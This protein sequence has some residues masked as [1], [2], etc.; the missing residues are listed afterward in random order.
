MGGAGEA[1]A[2]GELV[3]RYRLAA[4]LTQEEVAERAGLSARTVA[5][6]E[7]GRTARPYRRSVRALADALAL[8]EPERHEL[9][10]AG[11]PVPAATAIADLTLAGRA[12]SAGQQQLPHPGSGPSRDRSHESP[13]AAPKADPNLGLPSALKYSLPPDTAAFTGRDDEVDRVTSAASATRCAVTGAVAILAIGGMPGIGKTTLAVHAAHRLAASFPDRQLFLDLHGHTPGRNPVTSEEALAG[14]LT[15]DGVDPRYLPADLEGRAA[16][17]RDRMSGQRVLLVLDNAASSA[18]VMPLLPGSAGCLVL[19]TSRRHLA[20]LPGVVTSITLEVLPPEQA[21][22][23]FLLLAPRARA[24]PPAVAE[25]V[26]LAGC[27]PLAISLLARMFAR[28]P[29]WTLAD[30]VAETRARL[31]TLTAEH[32]SIAA[33]FELSRQ[34][35]EPGQQEFF[36]YLGLHPGNSVDAYSAAALAGVE[37]ED[38]GRLLET[39]HGEGLLTEVGYRRYGMHDLIRRY[40]AERAAATPTEAAWEAA[41][42]RLMAYYQQAASIAQARLAQ[43]PGLGLG[44]PAPIAQPEFADDLE[45]LAWAR[46]ERDSMLVCLDRAQQRG[47]R[48]GI[49]ALTAGMTE[50]LRRDGPWSEAVARHAAAVLA[51]SDAGDSAALAA[52]LISLADA[53]NLAGDYQAAAAS[54]ERARE[55]FADVGDRRG[56]AD[57]LSVLAD[58][59]R[60][61]GDLGAA[62]CLLERSLAVFGELGDRFGEVKA[63]RVLGEV[64]ATAGDHV[65]AARLLGQ[66]LAVSRA[67]GSRLNEARILSDLAQIGR[68]A[69]DHLAAADAAT[70]ALALYT[71]LGD[72]HGQAQGLRVRAEVA[73]ATGACRAAESDALQAIQI[74]RELGDQVGQA[75][76][77]QTLGRA[78][79]SA[80]NCAAAAAALEQSLAIFRDR[81]HRSGQANALLWL[82]RTCR[83]L[84]EYSAAARHLGEALRLFIDTGDRGGE[85]TTLNETG[86]LLLAREDVLAAEA[87]YR[88]GLDLARQTSSS[89]DEAHAMAGLGRCAAA[90]GDTPSATARLRQAHAIFEREG[91]AEAASIAAEIESLDPAGT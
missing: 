18:Q 76:A 86:A 28:H 54:A 42:A 36:S 56:Q 25:L 77:L 11:R 48:A 68:L 39:L 7:R 46:A 84:A 70:Q 75:Y 8:A 67:I 26:R 61:T 1:G 59:R 82:G 89:W 6:M 9:E 64:R 38:A 4:G 30:L 49:V 12:V 73:R 14:L 20:D 29:A 90:Y 63:L 65:Q 22:D 69:G 27:L 85:V 66:A 43:L 16:L 41:A 74:R 15:A 40:V 88:Q 17:W 37:P 35:L 19:V 3:R 60:L 78:R 34:H 31:L 2:F 24:D 87:R 91:A 58:V 47:D 5:N 55:A 57:A 71:E 72:R 45:A 81:G 10:R 79:E 52:A 21:Q 53:Q 80:G 83:S 23:M 50:L 51:A 44:M 13:S 32:V 62:A 33:A